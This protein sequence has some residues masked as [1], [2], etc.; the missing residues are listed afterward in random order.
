[1]LILGSA[2]KLVL[3]QFHRMIRSQGM[4]SNAKARCL[5]QQWYMHDFS[6]AVASN[7]HCGRPPCHGLEAFSRAGCG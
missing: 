3:L 5:A 2:L 6:L 4:Y 1:M 7:L